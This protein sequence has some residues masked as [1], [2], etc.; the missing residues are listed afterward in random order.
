MNRL[1]KRIF[2]RYVPTLPPG[3]RREIYAAC[4]VT[5]ILNYDEIFCAASLAEV[6]DLMNG[7]YAD[8]ATSIAKTNGVVDR[9]CGPDI[10]ALY[11]VFHGVVDN[12]GVA[13]AASSA[14]Y[15]LSGTSKPP[16]QLGVGV[17][18]CA[19]RM[20]YGDYG[21]TERAT[22][23]AFGPPTVCA[24][25]LARRQAGVNL[26]ESISA[27][28]GAEAKHASVSHI[29]WHRHVSSAGAERIGVKPGK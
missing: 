22:V 13:A 28:T 15:A 1:V 14:F 12:E 19:G 9:F 18:V 11:G 6:G 7:Y 8:G 10:I 3:L 23:T 17:G 25:S 20:I 21:S 5:H 4:L 26:C 27:S 16:M 29:R 2:S 24:A